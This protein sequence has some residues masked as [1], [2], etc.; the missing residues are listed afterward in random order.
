M[1]LPK[2]SNTSCK[3]VEIIET[4]EIALT[5]MWIIERYLDVNINEIL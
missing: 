3:I 1:T 2:L 4:I 5:G